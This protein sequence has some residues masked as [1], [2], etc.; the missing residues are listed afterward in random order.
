VPVHADS[1]A[2]VP[3]R[4]RARKSAGRRSG[5]MPRG[6]HEGAHLTRGGGRADRARRAGRNPRPLLHARFGVNG[7]A[8]RQVQPL[9]SGRH[10]FHAEAEAGGGTSGLLLVVRAGRDAALGSRG[11]GTPARREIVGPGR[12]VLVPGGVQRLTGGAARLPFGDG[13]D[14]SRRRLRSHFFHGRPP[15]VPSRGEPGRGHASIRRTPG[16][17][18]EGRST[19]RGTT[20]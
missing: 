3:R 13:R 15:A 16:S 14:A 11:C 10:C 7:V 19:E 2:L 12:R 9:H 8:V 4:R 20:I 5:T 17:G 6:A 1:V 18:G